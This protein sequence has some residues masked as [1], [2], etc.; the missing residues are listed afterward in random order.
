MVDVTTIKLLL[1]D[2]DGTLISST[3]DN[4]EGD[5]HTWRV[6]PGVGAVIDRVRQSGVRV[7]IVT[8]QGGVGKGVVTP[9]DVAI[10]LYQ[11]AVMLGFDSVAIIDSP[12][13]AKTPAPCVS[14]ALG[15]SVC[16][17][18]THSPLEE[19]RTPADIARRKPQ[20]AMLVEQMRVAGV[21]DP[22]HVM[23]VGDWHTDQKAAMSAGVHFVWAKDA[24]G[25][26]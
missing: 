5:Y 23:Y 4:P 2:V 24:F 25:W 8:N 6:L 17:S 1:C 26:T 3:M 10:K 20:P 12:V 22:A 13:A 15:A 18:Y 11:L 21:T 9:A 14:T 16:Y 19:W 7:G